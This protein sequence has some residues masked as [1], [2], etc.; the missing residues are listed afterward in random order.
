[1]PLLN[2]LHA[3]NAKDHKFIELLLTQQSTDVKVQP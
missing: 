1:M 2:Y 3:I